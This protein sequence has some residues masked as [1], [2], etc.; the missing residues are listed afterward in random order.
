MRRVKKHLLETGLFEN[1]GL[2]IGN[3]VRRFITEERSFSF[4]EKKV[5]K[6]MLQYPFEPPLI[7]LG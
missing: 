5:A 2:I 3:N 7:M 4:L 1:G 6:R